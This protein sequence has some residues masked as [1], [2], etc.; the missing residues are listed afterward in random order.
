MPGVES[1]ICICV[2]VCVCVGFTGFY[3]CIY[4]IYSIFIIYISLALYKY[5]IYDEILIKLNY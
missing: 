5:D 4:S 2:C 3:I 1:N